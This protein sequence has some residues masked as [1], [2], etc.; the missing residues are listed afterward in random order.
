M[1]HGLGQ[2]GPGRLIFA[3]DPRREAVFL[4]AGDKSSAWRT[5]YQTAV[6]LADERFSEHLRILKEQEGS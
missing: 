5:W 4:V 1:P 6:P 2:C 3:F